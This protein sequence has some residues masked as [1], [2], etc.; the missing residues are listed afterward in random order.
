MGVI[1]IYRSR[2]LTGAGIYILANAVLALI[3]FLLLPFLTRVLTPE[4]FG[5]VALFQL[6]VA[7][8]SVFTGLSV[9]G[10]VSVNYFK[11][12][13]ED[14]PQFVGACLFI[15][16][17]T[18]T[19]MVIV[20][21]FFL[22]VMTGKIGLDGNFILL[23]IFASLGQF[24]INIR[25]VIWQ[26]SDEPIKYGVFQVLLG[27]IS[28]SMAI[29]LIFSIGM[30]EDGRIM[31]MTIATL[32][33]SVAALVSLFRGGWINLKWNT[34]YI[35]EALKWGV[36]LIPH[37][38]GTVCML[39]ADRFIISNQLGVKYTG[40]YFVAIQLSLPITMLGDSY[41]R[42]FRPWLYEKL[43]EG[44]ELVGVVISYISMFVFILIGLVYSAIIYLIY[45]IVVGDQYAD[46]QQIS[47][48]LIFA[49]TLQILYYTVANHILYSG[50]TAILSLL[51][52]TNSIIYMAVGWFII[53]DFG[54]VGLALFFML[55]SLAFFVITWIVSNKV[56]SQPWFD[57]ANL[58]RTAIG[59]L[60]F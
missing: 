19:A 12:H 55:T 9:H 17:A 49:N 26:V 3:S 31:S 38:L 35:K 23:A 22:P 56:S 40:I 60:N 36:P 50:K 8:F 43:S 33:F 45:P 25:L 42:A 39:M 54:L 21:S 53:L 48:I 4:E 5:I 13:R 24:L 20:I 58:R 57:F 30:K 16:L 6:T 15:L 10:A 27:L 29:Y 44:E 41:N 34:G 46:G 32:M 51:S 18:S 11:G 59:M 14:F 47:V 7:V 2:L 28:A 1:K 52:I 37:V